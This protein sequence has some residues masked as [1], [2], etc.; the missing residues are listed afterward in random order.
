MAQREEG[1]VILAERAEESAGWAI[2]AGIM[3]IIGGLFAFL[4]GL[5]GALSGAFYNKVPDYSFGTNAT[6]WGWIVLIVGIIAFLAGVFV[7]SGA[8]WAR[9]AGIMLASLS[10]LANFFFIPFYPIWALVVVAL[11]VL[12]IWALT[13]H[14]KELVKEAHRRKHELR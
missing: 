3:L 1:E 11:N 14:G 10:A 9:I 7:I 13:V 5:A 6:S 12:V 4:E 2:F 8:S